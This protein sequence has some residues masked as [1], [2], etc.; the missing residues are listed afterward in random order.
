[1]TILH[2]LLF[3]PRS[4]LANPNETA[5]RIELDENWPSIYS[6]LYKSGPI[7]NNE[8]TIRNVSVVDGLVEEY[9]FPCLAK[10]TGSQK[11]KVYFISR[12]YDFNQWIEKRERSHQFPETRGRFVFAYSE[13]KRIL[14]FAAVSEQAP[15]L[16]THIRPYKRRQDFNK[17]MKQLG[18]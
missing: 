1:L 15:Q 14:R 18:E 4:S 5:T 3:W 9:L 2:S 10:K 11:L 16:Q 6:D 17:G 8:Y 13:E 12:E 7:F